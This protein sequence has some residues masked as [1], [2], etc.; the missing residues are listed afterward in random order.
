MTD[1]PYAAHPNIARLVEA[2]VD[3]WPDH[4]T[5]LEKSFGARTASLLDTSDR[6]A[7]AV[8]ELAADDVRGTAEDY[9]WLCDR[10]R[11][12][13]LNFARTDAYRF[14]TF[15]ET[16]AHVYSDD[17]FMKRY[18]N[19]LL[20]S[21]VLWFMHASSLHFFVQRLAARVKAGGKVLEVGSGHGLLLF[22]CLRDLKM[23]EAVAWDLSPVSLE[24]TRA[25]LARLGAEGRARFAVQDMHQAEATGEQFDLVILSHLLEHLDDPIPALA[26][27]RKLLTKDGVLFVNVPLNAPM[28]DHLQLL[29]DPSE[30]E[31]MLVDGGFRVLEIASHTTQAM[32]LGKALKRKAAVTCSI[33]AE[34]A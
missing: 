24:H 23:R 11:E 16:N 3:V 8:L 1:S 19:G 17:D 22:L 32:P 6:M 20:F 5:Y 12:E 4:G 30:A 9:R 15:E 10:I 18:M 31:K 25:A 29:R 27:V 26:T 33:I 2:V 34:P 28:P 7:A 13:E 21:H 14:S